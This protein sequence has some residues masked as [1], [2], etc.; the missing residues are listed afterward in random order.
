MYQFLFNKH[1]KI[2]KKRSL[3]AR[4]KRSITDRIPA[5]YVV[6]GLPG[7]LR[8]SR[9][10]QYPTWC[11][12][13]TLIETLTAL[14][15]LL[16]AI[17]ALSYAISPGIQT[18]KNSER[19]NQALILAQNKIEELVHEEYDSL[20][21]GV[22]EEQHRLSTDVDDPLYHYQREV[23]INWVD[24][25]NNLQSTAQESGIKKIVVHIF[26][27]AFFHSNDQQTELISLV[28]QK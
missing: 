12:G 20:A 5:P 8:G 23:I 16:V 7:T 11:R 28:S 6:R 2:N 25:E 3:L 24:P 1:P 18:N 15:V 27:P 17:F 14:T 10:T 21:V 19:S 13:F 9:F 22:F 4:T 26:W